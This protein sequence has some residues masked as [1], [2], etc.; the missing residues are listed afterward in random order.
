MTTLVPII[1]DVLL[2]VLLVAALMLGM[3]LE[4]RLKALRESHNGFAQAVNE[5]D[6]A[7]ARAEQGLAD[8]RAATDEAA[9]VLAARIEKA[10]ILSGRLETLAERAASAP[11]PQPARSVSAQPPLRPAPVRESSFMRPAPVATPRSRARVD[12]DLF[13]DEPGP[14]LRS[15]IGSR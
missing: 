10:Q 12:E 5:L 6:R 13:A 14:R 11:P 4:K 7:A 8:L 2:G 15:A 9:E 3:R 1:L